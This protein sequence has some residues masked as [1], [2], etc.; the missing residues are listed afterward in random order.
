MPKMAWRIKMKSLGL[1][2]GLIVLTSIFA[3]CEAGRIKLPEGKYEDRTSL[4]LAEGDIEATQEMKKFE[5]IEELKIFLQQRTS[6]SAAPSYGVRTLAGGMEDAVMAVAESAEG[7]P[8]PKAAVSTEEYSETNIQVEGVDEADFV[9][10]DGRYIY[11]IADDKLLIV[12]AYDAENAEIVS[13]TEIGNEYS[14]YY[15]RRTAKQLFING[16]RLVLFV[17][18]NEKGFYFEKYDIVPR[19]TYRP[20]LYVYTYD[21]TNRTDPD[22]VEKY[23]ITG[24][25]YQSRM[26]GD[27]VYAVT[28]ENARDGYY[29][30]E[31]VIARS[32]EPS[33]IKPEIY[34]FDNP[35]KNY[36]FNTITSIDI[37]EDEVI[38]AQTLMMGYSNTLMVSQNNIYIAYQKQQYWRWWWHRERYEKERFYDVILPLLEG[39]IKSDI[40]DV[41][42]TEMNEEAQWRAIS[43]ILSEF[44]KELED[45][46]EMQDEYEDMFGDI[47]D[48]LEEYDMKRS[49]E[50]RK[51]I[52]HKIGINE[53]RLKY[54]A[55]GEVYGSLLNQFSLDEHEGKLRLATTV[56]IWNK[57]RIQHNNVYVLDENMEKI[58]ELTRIAEDESIYS[59]RF[60]GDRLYMV[61]FKR[62][63]PFFVIDLSNSEKPEILGKL[64]I[65]GY[66]D[67][68]HPY[69]ENHI[70]GVGKETEANDWGGISTS[71]VKIAMFDVSDVE[72]PKEIDKIEIGERGS[73]S[74][75]LHDHKAFL[76]S[77]EKNLLVLPVT[78]VKKREKLTEYRYSNTIWSGAYVFDVD[79][80][81]FDEI[82]KLEHSS[83]KSDY[84]YWRDQAT[85][86]RSLYMDDNLY[87][88]SSKYIKINDLS[89]NLKELNTV[90]LPYEGYRE[91][92]PRTI[93]VGVEAEVIE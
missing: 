43:K 59:T 64:K 81:G 31:P 3:G 22:I 12:D 68:L 2:I 7:A 6:A 69:D 50:G 51:T 84:L 92:K 5:S 62:I 25:Y 1:M 49:L 47:A 77:K 11:I 4:E 27:I 19:D 38:D 65:P 54:K 35:E 28:Q 89:K 41:L 93:M 71:G 24:R 44:Y 60:M 39:K 82:G 14:D 87:T 20:R 30:N 23:S 55:K 61:T 37:I 10:N 17:E 78:E 58:G 75:V 67:Y 74:A 21:I 76:F 56:D 52:I 48:A 42:N 90:K 91:P 88:I 66:S 9:K 86:L 83:S 34:Y 36:Q 85:V 80:N 79:E 63:D 18:A 26:I 13:E 53:G 29:I 33:V 45:D 70:I 16:D 40:E 8:A 46:E 32:V 73:D 57:K 15:S 72:N